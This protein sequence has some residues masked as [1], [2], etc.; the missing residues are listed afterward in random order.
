MSDRTR[1]VACHLEACWQH[2]LG[3]EFFELSQVDFE[4]ENCRK[5]LMWVAP[6]FED[7]ENQLKCECLWKSIA[8]LTALRTLAG[9]EQLWYQEVICLTAGSTHFQM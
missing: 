2:L 3:L 1:F 4:M 6:L 8:V 9:P 5:M 7:Y